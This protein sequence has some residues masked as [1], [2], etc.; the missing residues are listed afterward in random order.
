MKFGIAGF[1]VVGKSVLKFIQNDF[2]KTVL[3]NL[4]KDMPSHCFNV[5]VQDDK[6]ASS[7]DAS[8]INVSVWDE[9]Q[10]SDQELAEI[11]KSDAIFVNSKQASLGEFI[12]QNDLVLVSPGLNLKSLSDAVKNKLI[13]ELDLFQAA[14][15]KKTIAIT[16]TLGKTTT[17]KL[18]GKLLSLKYNTKI[19]G[20]IGIGMLDLA[21]TKTQTDIAVLELSSFQL[22]LNKSFAPGIAIWTNFH[23]NHLD[24]HENETDYFE[25]KFKIL[26]Y[27]TN[28]QYA[29]LSSS[30][31]DGEFG[32]SFNKKLLELKSQICIIADKEP[33][34]DFL[35]SISVQNFKIFFAN[36]NKFYMSTVLNHVQGPVHELF[37]LKTLPPITFLENWLQVITTLH[38]CN[39][40]L[41]IVT[42][43]LNSTEQNEILNDS[44]HRVENFATINDIAFY[45]D[46]KSTVIQATLAAVKLL[47]QQNKPIYLILGGLNKGVDRSSLLPEL[48]K[49]TQIK[50]IYSFGTNIND[51]EGTLCMPNLD[52][53]IKNIKT[54]ARPGEIVLFSPAGTS[55]DFFKN[56]EHRG[57]VFKELV[58]KYFK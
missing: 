14:F 48:K 40:D 4:T 56:Y 8:C 34:Q 44:H 49:I 47:A 39:V 22:R 21:Q 32:N 38:L 1:G 5:T 27:Q 30:L 15:D 12:N 23:P 37:D 54:D 33:N 42:K 45:D 55:F 36:E 9:R 29:V 50:R 58:L 57:Q 18:L 6:T 13:C 11:Q 19:G 52:E 51:F 46:S 26:K 24:I 3:I 7:N 35:N 20:N 43:F 16:G 10:Q 53:I 28:E 31:F 2:G 25:S 17:T 41:K